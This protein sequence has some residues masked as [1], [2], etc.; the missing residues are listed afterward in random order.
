MKATGQID[1]DSGTEY[2]TVDTA[3]DQVIL[4]IMTTVLAEPCNPAD[5][6]P[7]RDPPVVVDPH[8]PRRR[9]RPPCRDRFIS[10]YFQAALSV[11]TGT[12][13]TA[14]S[15]DGMPSLAEQG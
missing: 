8:R 2:A 1:R 6:L 11:R 12:V 9:P 14:C 15:I 13:M 5:D 4:A 7:D 10:P 3:A